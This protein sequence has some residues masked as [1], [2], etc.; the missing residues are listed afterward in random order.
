M[1][2]FLWNIVKLQRAFVSLIE[3]AIEKPAVPERFR[4][5][6]RVEPRLFPF[7]PARPHESH[8]AMVAGEDAHG[9]TAALPHQIGQRGRLFRVQ[10][11]QFADEIHLSQRFNQFHDGRG[12]VRAG[13]VNAQPFADNAQGYEFVVEQGLFQIAHGVTP[14]SD[15]YLDGCRQASDSHLVD[16][17]ARIGEHLAVQLDRHR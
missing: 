3:T 8:L 14:R 9:R 7:Q 17:V 13:Q 12:L 1:E 11:F 10:I 15:H 16:V 5:A 2:E 6:G 4:R